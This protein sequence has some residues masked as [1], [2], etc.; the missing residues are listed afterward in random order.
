[1]NATNQPGNAYSSTSKSNAEQSQSVA[2]TSSPNFSSNNYNGSIS[3]GSPIAQAP[4]DI[5]SPSAFLHHHANRFKSKLI[6][7]PVATLATPYNTTL[8]P[9]LTWNTAKNSLIILANAAAIELY[10]LCVEDDHDAEKLCTKCSEKFFLNLSLTE[11]ISQAPLIA[12]CIQVLGRLA[13]KYPN[14]SKISNRHLTDFLTVPSPILLKQYKHIVE[15]LNTL[16]PSNQANGGGARANAALQT[17]NSLRYSDKD[18]KNSYVWFSK[19]RT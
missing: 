15:K 7:Q 3:T 16:K 13:L 6:P 17:S 19:L 5:K 8:K 14:L 9:S 4:Q 10:F 12:S 18:V 11:T 1:M 2:V